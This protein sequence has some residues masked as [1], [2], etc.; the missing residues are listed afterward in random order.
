MKEKSLLDVRK[1]GREE[2]GWEGEKRLSIFPQV[3]ILG[4]IRIEQHENKHKNDPPLTFPGS[5]WSQH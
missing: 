2:G 3:Q 5:L 4:R 1:E